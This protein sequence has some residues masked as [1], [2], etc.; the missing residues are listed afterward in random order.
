MWLDLLLLIIGCGALYVGA[1]RLIGGALRLGGMFR[2]SAALTGVLIVAVGTSLPELA[3]SVDAA[4]RSHG[5]IAV[6][7]VVGSNIVN[8]T[9]VLGAGVVIGHVA[10]SR[11][12]RRW[13]LPF[14]LILTLLS[15]VLLADFRI[16]RLEGALLLGIT[17]V[18][19]G[20]RLRVTP[21]D[22]ETPG[23]PTLTGGGAGWW[24][25]AGSVALGI[26]LLM[27]GAEAMVSSGVGLAGRLGISEA[28]IALTVTAIGTGIPEIAATLLAISRGHHDLALGN[29]VG[30]NVMNLG[31]VLGVSSL[32][33]PLTVAGLGWLP[34]VTMGIATAAL[35]LLVA[36]SSRL[37]WWT[38]LALLAGFGC[39]QVAL[40]A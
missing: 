33:A 40:L 26:G 37:K 36:F 9:L 5:E 7:S 35:C 4:L 38:G 30:S 23:E 32:M 31:L 15:I 29:I 8:I 16:G 1:D 25:C 19:V 17:I 22:L 10:A 20:H 13:D 39:Y 21:S 27:F 18:L 6:G 12:L 34:V 14:L 2:M 28:V 3:V 24:R 11:E